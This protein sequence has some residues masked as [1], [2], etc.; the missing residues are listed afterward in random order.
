MQA[1]A[2]KLPR[3]SLTQVPDM[4]AGAAAAAA[5]GA[6][7]P[8]AASAAPVG[9]EKEQAQAAWVALMEEVA[10]AISEAGD[11]NRPPSPYTLQYPVTYCHPSYT[12]M[13][14]GLAPAGSMSQ[15]EVAAAAA[16]ANVPMAQEGGMQVTAGLPDLRSTA[17]QQQQQLAGLPYLAQAYQQQYAQ[18]LQL[19][20]SNTPDKP[21][22]RDGMALD[23]PTAHLAL[24]VLQHLGELATHTSLSTVIGW[25]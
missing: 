25:G 12:V 13:P 4:A 23:V 8:A 16:A 7:A 19:S 14:Q 11:Y 20:R 6:A 15:G 18:G 17:A 5:A 1:P 22:W 10:W 21:R 2:F 24:Q 9:S 3:A